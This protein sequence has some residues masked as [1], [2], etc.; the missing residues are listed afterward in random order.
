MS[1]AETTRQRIIAAALDRASLHGMQGLSLGELSAALGMS[2]SGVFAHFGSKE[3]LQ[4]A[5][6]DAMQ[7]RFAAVVWRPARA[8][9]PGRARLAAVFLNWLAWVDGHHLPGG[10][11]LTAAAVELDDQ[12][13]PLRDKL[14]EGQRQWQTLLADLVAAACDRASPTGCDRDRAFLLF[15]MVLAYA[16]TSRLLRDPAA[17]DRTLNA[18]TRI[19]GFQAADGPPHPSPSR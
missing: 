12:P 15:G 17:R 18:F 7:D 3:A 8:Q 14:V 4:A 13:G 1:K 2:K 10:C 19:M 9:P 6:L 16:Q 11:P 5:L